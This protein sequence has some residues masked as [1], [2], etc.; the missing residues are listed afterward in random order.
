ML[1]VILRPEAAASGTASR[2]EARGFETLIAPVTRI[3]ATGRHAPAGPFDA[4]IVTSAHGLLGTQ[5]GTQGLG[6][7]GLDTARLKLFAVGARTAAAAQA[8][9]FVDIHD[10]NGDA[11]TLA[12]LIRQTMP[13]GARLLYLAGELRKPELEDLLRAAGFVLTT[14]ETYRATPMAHF[15]QAAIDAFSTREDCA[16][17]HLSRS[18][19]ELAFDLAGKAGLAARF[20][21]FSHHALSEDV[22]EPARRAGV[23]RLVIAAKPDEPHLLDTLTAG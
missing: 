21:S 7:Q 22:A 3:E 9:G 8:S 5:G 12:A 20:A 17:L 15:D 14:V 23:A 11:R 6:A 1:V 16:I 2:A 10:A 18:H 19:A 4:V 13:A